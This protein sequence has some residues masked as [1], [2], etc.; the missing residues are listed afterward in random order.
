MTGARWGPILPRLPPVFLR[1][2]CDSIFCLFKF[3]DTHHRNIC[4]II[5]ELVS[6][7]PRDLSFV[8]T[9]THQADRQPTTPLLATS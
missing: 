9:K 7:S 5:D 1:S 3:L 6:V 4:N 2:V 8:L